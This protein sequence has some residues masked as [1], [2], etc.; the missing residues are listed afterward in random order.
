MTR[1][2]VPGLASPHP[3][4]LQLPALYQED[5]FALGFTAALDE[6]LAP[7]FSSLDNFDSYLD[8][9]LAPEDFLDW[10]GGWLGLVLD[11]DWPAERRRAFLA[12]ASAVYR[13][14]GTPQG[15]VDHV[16]LV[17]GVE[18]EIIESGATAWSTTAGVPVPG[19]AGFELLVRA[20]VQRG[21]ELDV[22]TLDSLVAASK[23]AHV[24]HSVEVLA[25]P[26]AKSGSPKAPEEAPEPEDS[27]SSA[28]EKETGQESND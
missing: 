8:P 16:R 11:E 27:D 14:R 2:L 22:A 28:P 9:D 24:L 13:I 10:L 23:P 15:L 17:T 5:T 7:V 3:M 26:A 6:V 4:G 18:V 25:P 21:S 20:R 19:R 12:K 1:A